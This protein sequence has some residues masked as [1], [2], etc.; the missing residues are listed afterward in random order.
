MKNS[1][2]IFVIAS[3]FIFNALIST[4]AKEVELDRVAV[5]VNNGV[6]LESEIQDLMTSVKKQSQENNQSLPS[7]LN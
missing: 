2:K 4:Q 6:I 1:L 5:I 3:S 7:D